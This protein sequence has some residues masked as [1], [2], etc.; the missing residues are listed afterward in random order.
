VSFEVRWSGEDD[1]ANV[2]NPGNGFAGEYV[3]TR[4]AREDG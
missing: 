1:H 3:S 2:K 4:A